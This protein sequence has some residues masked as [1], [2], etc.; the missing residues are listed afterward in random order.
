[1]K[2]LAL[3]LSLV[4]GT[5]YAD[6][7]DD[8]FDL[9]FKAKQDMVYYGI[10]ERAHSKALVRWLEIGTNAMLDDIKDID[11]GS[12][13]RSSK[14]GSYVLIAEVHGTAFRTLTDY[15]KYESAIY[16]VT[17]EKQIDKEWRERYT[18]WR[19]AIETNADLEARHEKEERERHWWQSKPE[20]SS[21]HLYNDLGIKTKEEF[22]K[23]YPPREKRIENH[24]GADFK[25]DYAKKVRPYLWILEQEKKYWEL[26]KK[27]GTTFDDGDLADFALNDIKNGY[28]PMWEVSK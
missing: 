28:E 3:V 25:K 14:S 22:F 15:S 19:T 10:D 24:Y 16:D 5:L 23:I 21:C 9:W 8:R 12:N 26:S 20:K 27:H 11:N 7:S 17:K 4:V 18:N 2:S 13:T 6:K 1:M